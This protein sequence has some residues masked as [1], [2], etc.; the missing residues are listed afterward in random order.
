MGFRFSTEHAN[1]LAHVLQPTGATPR[2]ESDHGQQATLRAFV[3]S[4]SA[5]F[6]SSRHE[7]RALEGRLYSLLQEVRAQ[8]IVSLDALR[9]LREY[10]RDTPWVALLLPG[11][12]KQ[13][14][15]LLTSRELLEE[16][17]RIGP[18]EPGLILQLHCLPPNE[19]R[20]DQAFPAFRVALA[21]GNRWPGILLW[22]PSGEAVFFELST[23]V[24]E[25]RARATWLLSRLADRYGPPDLEE[26]KREFDRDVVGGETSKP[27]PKII[28]ID[29]HFGS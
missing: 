12:D 10:F 19:T 21:E 16:L 5:N 4:F 25:V 18:L 6:H 8:P 20:L 15:E 24:G 26:L 11:G 22:T 14:D 2:L 29:L 27:K 23:D 1:W 9:A 13:T 3:E 17:V 28:H 7:W